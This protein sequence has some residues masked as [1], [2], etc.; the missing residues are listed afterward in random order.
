MACNVL[1]EIKNKIIL[2]NPTNFA[3]TIYTTII[4]NATTI[5]INNLKVWNLPVQYELLFR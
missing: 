2:T 5:D 4:Q 1:P 3:P